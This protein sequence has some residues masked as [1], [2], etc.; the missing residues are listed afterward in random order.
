MHW[1]TSKFKQSV[2]TLASSVSSVGVRDK[3]II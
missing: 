1:E 2:L 3:N